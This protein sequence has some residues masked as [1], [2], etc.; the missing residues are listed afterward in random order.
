MRLLELSTTEAT[1]ICDSL[2]RHKL[3]QWG[4]VIF[5]CTYKS[6]EKWDKFIGFMKQDAS[7]YFEWRGMEDVYD[8]MAWTI[9][10]DADA[11]EGTDLATTARFTQWVKG[12]EGRED[13]DGSIFDKGPRYTFFL[14]ADEES[15]ESVVDDAK[16]REASGYFCKVVRAG[17]ALM[18]EQEPEWQDEGDGQAEEEEDEEEE[19]VDVRK[20]VKIDALVPFYAIVPS[21][22]MWYNIGIKEGVAF[23]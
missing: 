20:R 8:R 11:L 10:E 12:P 18:P 5:R 15:L 7:D 2:E 6:Q 14:H 3:K 23:F 22:N 1:D 17:M 13:R 19:L 16:A 9:I 21:T 4:F